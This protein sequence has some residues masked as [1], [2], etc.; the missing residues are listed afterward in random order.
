MTR[1]VY[2]DYKTRAKKQD[3]AVNKSITVVSTKQEV[4]DQKHSDRILH[5]QIKKESLHSEESKTLKRSYR[6][7]LIHKHRMTLTKL[8]TEFNRHTKEADRISHTSCRQVYSDLIPDIDDPKNFC[9]VCN[10]GFKS[11]LYILS[12]PQLYFG[13]K[14][15]RPN[16][17]YITRNRYFSSC[18]KFLKA[19]SG[20]VSKCK[21]AVSVT[22][23]FNATTRLKQLLRCEL[24][25]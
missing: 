7:H 1:Q 5:F 12:M 10:R 6:R 17:K 14:D 18:Y 23:I 3:I 21:Y 25:Q 24:F 2:I 15:T 20:M 9:I 13:A 19:N 16:K 22:K 4:D 11:R 8:S